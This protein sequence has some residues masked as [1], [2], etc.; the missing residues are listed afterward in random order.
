[1]QKSNSRKWI[2]AAGVHAWGPGYGD[3]WGDSEILGYGCLV[4]CLKD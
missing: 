1:M 3:W 4:R 2:H